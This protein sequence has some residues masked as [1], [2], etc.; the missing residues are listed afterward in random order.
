MAKL[1][2]ISGSSRKGSFNTALAHAFGNALPEGS[3]AEFADYADVPLYNQDLEASAYPEPVKTLKAKI[4]DADGIVIATPEYN[5]S[6]PGY[7][8][9]MIDWTS[10]PYG[11]NAWAG[12]SVYVTGASGG[13]IGTALAQY[14]L[15]QSLLYLDARIM[16]Q[17]E[18]YV[19][20][21]AEKFAPAPEAYGAGALEDDSTKKHL[22]D[23]AAAFVAFIDKK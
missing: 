11:D 23:A 19:N 21:A 5:R 20:F 22:A 7:L 3:T 2:L 6:V 10:R 12:K 9:N 1:L 18:T 14:A 17:P 16:G 8:K 13:V 4:R 15:K